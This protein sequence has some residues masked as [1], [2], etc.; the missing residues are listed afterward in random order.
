MCL[1][2]SCTSS[3]KALTCECRATT[4]SRHTSLASS[5]CKRPSPI[6]NSNFQWGCSPRYPTQRLQVQSTTTSG[7][8]ARPAPQ[9]RHHST[10]RSRSSRACSSTVQ[11]SGMTD[12]AAQRALI[13]IRMYTWSWARAL[14]VRRH[15]SNVRRLWNRSCARKG[16]SC[17]ACARCKV[18]LRSVA[19]FAYKFTCWS[20]APFCRSVTQI[21]RIWTTLL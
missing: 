9:A 18:R 20:F 17:A 4:S 15:R 6:A 3:V 21:M 11:G 10:F 19:S 2:S 16:T 12:M 5:G 1:T 7:V 8:R 14:S 13:L